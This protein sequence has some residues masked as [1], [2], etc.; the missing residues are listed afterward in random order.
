MT[1]IV[2]S[3]NL[4]EKTYQIIGI[5]TNQD[6]F[7]KHEKLIADFNRNPFHKACHYLVCD[8][9]VHKICKNLHEDM[10]MIGQTN[11]TTCVFPDFIR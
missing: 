5:K 1:E 9:E 3:R 4:E 6:D 10:K 2:I 11:S 7:K 8:S